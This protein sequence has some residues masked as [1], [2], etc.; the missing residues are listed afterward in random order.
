MQRIIREQFPHHT[1]IMIAHRL[2]SLLDFDCVAV[3]DAGSVVE[4]G[5]PSEL[6]KDKRS[7]FAKLANRS[8]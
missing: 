4:V 2:S 5:K 3:F 6:L 1:I 8:P 7:H